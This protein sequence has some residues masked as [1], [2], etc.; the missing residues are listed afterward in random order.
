MEKKLV[1]LDSAWLIPALAPWRNFQFS[2]PN[3]AHGI[4]DGSITQQFVTPKRFIRH[5]I[6]S[7]QTNLQNALCSYSK[8]QERDENTGLPSRMPF[9]RLLGPISRQL[10][11]G[12][13]NLIDFVCMLG[14]SAVNDEGGDGD[15]DHGNSYEK[16]SMQDTCTAIFLPS[17]PHYP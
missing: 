2:F 14:L 5:Q 15:N 6:N 17:I 12:S 11:H 4:I 8:G 1:P 16:C 3:S 9:D 13:D 10:H 7:H